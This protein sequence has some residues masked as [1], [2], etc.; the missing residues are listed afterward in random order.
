MTRAVATHSVS[1]LRKA[2]THNHHCQLLRNVGTTNPAT[3][4]AAEHGPLLSQ[5]R[6]VGELRTL[7]RATALSYPISTA[8]A[9]VTTSALSVTVFSSEGACTAMVSAKNRASAT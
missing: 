8:S 3:T 4:R 5:G 6:L 9:P 2:G 1:S 7:V